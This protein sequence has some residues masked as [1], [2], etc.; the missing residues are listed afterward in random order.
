MTSLMGIMAK[1]WNTGLSN[2]FKG[3]KNFVG[4]TVVLGNFE[5]H[6]LRDINSR[7]LLLT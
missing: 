7:L 1:N 2:D 6:R 4:V 3:Q 5:F